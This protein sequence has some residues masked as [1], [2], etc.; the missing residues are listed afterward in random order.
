MKK[1]IWIEALRFPMAFLVVWIH[2][3]VPH[4]EWDAV[5]FSDGLSGDELYCLLGKLFSIT[6]CS[7]AVPLFMFISGYLLFKNVQNT[8][9]W[10]G[11]IKEANQN[12]V[13]TIY[14]MDFNLHH[15][16]EHGITFSQYC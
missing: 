7:A 14:S 16:C 8:Y 4:I 5:K 9:L 6:I 12:T 1:E 13:A 11:Q 3:F 15:L 2:C 10:G